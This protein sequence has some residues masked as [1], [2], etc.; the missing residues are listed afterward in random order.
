MGRILGVMEQ[1][2]QVQTQTQTLNAGV[3]VSNDI[4][5]TWLYG[6]SCHNNNDDFIDC[7]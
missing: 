1:H 5:N 6:I 4:A 2:T 7:S 3:Y